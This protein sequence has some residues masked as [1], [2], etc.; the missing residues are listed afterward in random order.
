LI[1]K[2]FKLLNI[3]SSLHNRPIVTEGMNIFG[4]LNRE[5]NEKPAKY[6]NNSNKEINFRYELNQAYH[7]TVKRVEADMGKN[8]AKRTA[9]YMQDRF[10]E[11]INEF[12]DKEKGLFD[13]QET[14]SANYYTDVHDEHLI[15]NAT[16]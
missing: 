15:E 16:Y 8:F 3:S 14:S 9:N 10:Q 11:L 2:T 5:K 6:Y 7:L 12:N 1:N 4:G 13:S